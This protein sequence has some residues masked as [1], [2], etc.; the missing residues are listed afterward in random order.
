MQN[1]KG[2]KTEENL[3]N[4]FV[5][6]SQVFTKYN[7]Y[8]FKAKQDGYNEISQIF[9]QTA[10]NERAHAELWFKYLHNNAMPTTEQNL[11][12]SVKGEDFESKKL[13]PEYAKTA[14]DE[15]FDE[16]AQLFD[17]VAKIEQSHESKFQ[18]LLDDI[19]KSQV[20]VKQ[21]DTLWICTNCGHTLVDKGAPQS[22]PVCKQPQAYYKVKS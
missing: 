16:I 17:E 4:A 9:N 8:S 3:I 2:T 21:S 15:G 6:E 12:S 19:Q 13:Y 20:F 10:N 5:G 7:F 22:C 18:T 14:R 1:I 11:Q